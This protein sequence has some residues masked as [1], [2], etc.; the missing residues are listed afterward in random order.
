MDKPTLLVMAAGTGSRYGGLK[1]LEHITSEG[2]VIMDFSLYD[3]M[4]AGFER[5]VFVIREEYEEEVRAHISD[6]AGRYMETEYVFQKAE[7]MPDGYA[8]PEGRPN[9]WGTA[10]AVLAA[11][12]V[13]SGP[14]AVVNA[15]DF[16]GPG[17]FQV[18]YDELS[19]L[20][21]GLPH[22]YCMVG[23]RLANT[24]TENGTVARGI[25]SLTRDGR[26]ERI[27]ERTQIANADG[28]PCYTEN[29]GKDWTELPADAVVSMN[30]WGLTPSFFDTAWKRFPAFLDK[31]LEENPLKAE[32]ML[33]VAVQNDVDEG[34]ATVKILHTGD[35]WYGMTYREDKEDVESAVRSMKDKGLYPE[36]LWYRPD[37]EKIIRI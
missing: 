10:H 15:D 30:F 21:D 12:D 1:Q 28:V 23:F 27:V 20:K 8:V 13:I 18:M 6:G 2:E 25:C 32:Y 31:A 26:F 37:P 22:P 34:L 35:R 3:A 11:R 19:Q 24:L 29:G 4:M 5:A 17:A 14:F 7:D 9:P 33:P 16:Y 36:K